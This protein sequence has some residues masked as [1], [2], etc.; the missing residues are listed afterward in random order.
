MGTRPSFK[1]QFNPRKCLIAFEDCVKMLDSSVTTSGQLSG[2]P[3]EDKLNALVV[4]CQEKNKR[5]PSWLNSPEGKNKVA[6]IETLKQTIA[7]VKESRKK[8][9]QA[10]ARKVNL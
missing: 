8:T 2:E 6:D 4:E 7:T 1:E 10:Q 5:D 3:D 9:F